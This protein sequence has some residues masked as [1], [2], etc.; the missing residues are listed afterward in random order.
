MRI[1]PLQVAATMNQA[2]LASVRRIPMPQTS[3]T[4]SP[5]PELP[6][7]APPPA[8]AQT[9]ISVSVD[10]DKNVIYQFLDMR[11][12]EVVQQVPPEQ[13]LQVMRSIADLLRQSEQKLEITV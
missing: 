4:Q 6:K 10:S 9:Q 1:D 12:G 11:T 5:R 13:V 7:A 2:D 3:P 8:P